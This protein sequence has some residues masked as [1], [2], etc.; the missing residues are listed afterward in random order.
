MKAA[1]DEGVAVTVAVCPINIAMLPESNSPA[2][3]MKVYSVPLVR[4]ITLK[5][6][7]AP[8]PAERIVLEKLPLPVTPCLIT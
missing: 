6:L 3:T 4:L 8:F 5:G 7:V 2:P 1:Y